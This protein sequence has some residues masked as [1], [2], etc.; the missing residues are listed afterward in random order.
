MLHDDEQ[1]PHG[2]KWK[3]CACGSLNSPR[4]WCCDTPRCGKV[5]WEQLGLHEKAIEALSLKLQSRE[6]Q[7]GEDR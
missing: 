1:E 2:L 4:T 7:H 5:R 6:A 3:C